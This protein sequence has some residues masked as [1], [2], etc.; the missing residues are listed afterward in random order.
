[1]KFSEVVKKTSESGT[2]LHVQEK[3]LRVYS[4]VGVLLGSVT[5]NEGKV[6]NYIQFLEAR[7]F[8]IDYA[9]NHDYWCQFLKVIE[10]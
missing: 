2:V 4:V 9:N 3:I 5:H 8:S 10:D 1:M 7:T 6:G